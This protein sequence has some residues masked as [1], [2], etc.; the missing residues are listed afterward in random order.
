MIELEIKLHAWN[1]CFDI[2]LIDR[3]L[4]RLLIRYNINMIIDISTYF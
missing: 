1:I 3:L 4:D 2:R